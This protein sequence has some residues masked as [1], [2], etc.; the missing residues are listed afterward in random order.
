MYGVAAEKWRVR[1]LANV[2]PHV[3]RYVGMLDP[4]VSVPHAVP[5][6]LLIGVGMVVVFWV[7]VGGGLE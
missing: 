2:S 6:G 5:V 3:L 7:S 1:G 4:D